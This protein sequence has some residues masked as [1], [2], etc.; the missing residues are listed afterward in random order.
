M[1]LKSLQIENIRSYDKLTVNFPDGTILFEGA[2]GSG[3]STLLMAIEFALFGLG[4]IRGSSL[5]R[6]GTNKGLVK[7]NF[8]IEENQYEV[9]RILERKG[10]S[11]RQST[12]YIIEPSGKLDLEP[13]ELKQKI[14][15]I[16]HFNEPED[17]KAQSWIY[18]YAVFTPQEEMKAILTYKPDFRLEILRKA[19]RLEEYK[20]AIENTQTLTQELNNKI[21]QL[22]AQTKDLETR[23][24][25]Q[26]EKQEEKNKTEQTITELKDKESQIQKQLQE[27]NTQLDKLRQDNI[28]LE[29][30][31]TEI[32]QLEYQI[33]N[34]QKEKDEI[35]QEEEQSK[36]ELEHIKLQL[37]KIDKPKKPTTLSKNKIEKIIEILEDK[38]IELRKIENQLDAKIKDYKEIEKE[39]KCPTCDRRT[40]KDFREIVKKKN[41]E[42]EKA[43]KDVE[44]VSTKFKQ[45]RELLRKLEKYLSN[46]EK[47]ESIIREKKQHL[48]QIGKAQTKIKTLEKRIQT[49]NKRLEELTETTK[50]LTN[51]TEQI[52]EL[53]ENKTTKLE[54][55]KK[56]GEQI[57]SNK[58]KIEDISGE[59]K[60]LTKQTDE[61]KKDQKN[62]TILS[63]YHFWLRDYFIKTLEIVEKQVMTSINQ[64]FNHEFDK[65]FTIL[66]E[67]PT[68]QATI[69]GD[70]TPIIRQDG[71]DQN[72]E[73]LSGGEK[74]SVA[75][76]Y[77]L[78]LN[79]I[80]QQVSIGIKSNILIMDE[81]TDGFS[82]E[83]LYKV[84]EILNELQCPQ[85]ILVSHETELES[86]ADHIYRIGKIGGISK[87]QKP[88]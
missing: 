12:G 8:E 33:E 49:T 61:M 13:S 15:D 21:I 59:I 28:K 66:I 46:K 41:I 44:E 6:L 69:D 35:Q 27:L 50:E 25:Q 11:I 4:S 29:K 85:I 45:S 74:T 78:A 71:Y 34:D 42:W 81:P 57:A 2:T 18:R 23:Q 26:K 62:V 63:D 32:S 38:Q 52:T 40:T 73:F 75:L 47:I 7:L 22:K 72:V 14:L 24:K 43:Q 17:P 67:D 86:F 80:V 87:I 48:K 31:S 84:R 83:Q 56:I 68:K 3:K 1:K 5:L 79:S 53:K 19:F 77:R 37:S 65:W 76:A 36:K 64:E 20:T 10:K 9:C 30:A 55:S 70:F 39:K 82:K 51:I 54:E 58:Q 60:E 88:A 16:L